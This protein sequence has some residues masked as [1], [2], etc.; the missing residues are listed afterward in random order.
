MFSFEGSILIVDF[1]P[2]AGEVGST[3]KGLREISELGC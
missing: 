1:I 2:G 3:G